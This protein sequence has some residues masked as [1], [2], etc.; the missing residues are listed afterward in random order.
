MTEKLGKTFKEKS[1][2]GKFKDACL[3]SLGL[4]FAGTSAGLAVEYH[5]SKPSP[6]SAWARR[7][8]KTEMATYVGSAMFFILGAATTSIAVMSIR[9]KL[10]CCEP[11]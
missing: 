11:K 4:A 1:G 9:G 3:L 10:N 6:D 8:I 7:D 2:F 5:D